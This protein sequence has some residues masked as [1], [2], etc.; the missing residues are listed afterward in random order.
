MRKVL[1]LMFGIVLVQSTAAQ[2]IRQASHLIPTGKG[3]ATADNMPN[4][5]SSSTSSI[6]PASNGI[7]YHGGKVISGNVNVYFIWY[8]NW[9]NG[10]SASDSQLTV[11]L[12]DALYAGVGG[13]GSSGYALIDS[14]YSDRNHRASNSFSLTQST[15]DEYSQGKKLSDLAVRNIVFSAIQ[16]RRLPR[17]GNGIYFVLTSSDVDET[18]GFCNQYCGWHDHAA[19]LGSDIKFAF[20]GNP[21]RCSAACEEQTIGPNGDSGADGMASTMAHETVEAITDPDLNAW[22]D[23]SGAESADK[24]AWTYGPVHGTIGYGAYNQT[25]GTHN[26]LIQM[27]WENN[28]GGGCVQAKGG[29][30]YNR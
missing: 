23:S 30:F 10:P 24:C 22:Y 25:F 28:R 2:T 20:V 13:M 14:T 26:W 15:A 29:P 4:H 9:T 8:G 18:S 7:N 6:T 1:V 21:D 16:S 27:T 11:S 3:W 5:A 17:D 12:L 19:L